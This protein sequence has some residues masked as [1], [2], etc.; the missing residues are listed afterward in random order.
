MD[1]KE[2]TME[3]DIVTISASSRMGIFISDFVLPLSLVGV[4]GSLEVGFRRYQS[5]KI[6][7]FLK[8]KYNV[9]SSEATPIKI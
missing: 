1:V 3:A 6:A 5:F 7:G 2:R 8:L 9:F 4:N